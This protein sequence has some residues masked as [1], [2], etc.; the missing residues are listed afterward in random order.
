[1]FILTEINSLNLGP[2]VTKKVYISV[3]TYFSTKFKLSRILKLISILEK[4]VLQKYFLEN[5]LYI[6]VE[7]TLLNIS[8]QSSIS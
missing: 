3:N 8:F 5:M 4:Y 6:Q 2:T 7:K 1:M